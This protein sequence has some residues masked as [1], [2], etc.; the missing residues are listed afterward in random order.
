MTEPTDNSS[1][2]R[3]TSLLVCEGASLYGLL[4]LSLLL[5]LLPDQFKWQLYLHLGNGEDFRYWRLFTA[6]FMHMSW[7]HLIGNGI[8][9]VILQQVYGHCFRNLTWLYAVVFL[10]VSISV[11][12]ILTSVELSWY[13]GLSGVV[14][15]LACYAALTDE[16]Y[17]V[18]FNTLVL[19]ALIA[20]CGFFFLQGEVSDGLGLVPVASFSHVLGIVC[21]VFIGGVVRIAKRR[22]ASSHID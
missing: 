22:T 19:S 1:T 21:G 14:I 20:Y 3:T 17:T 11:G 10:T 16:H 8:C 13:V 9:I 18:I 7:Q 12:L 15:G 2:I 5:H 4:A 6:H